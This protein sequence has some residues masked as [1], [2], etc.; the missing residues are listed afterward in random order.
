M[1]ALSVDGTPMP[2]LP[3]SA[4]QI[5]YDNTTSGLSA[6]TVKGAVDELA[7]EKQDKSDDSLQ[8]TDK[9]IPGAIN[10]LKSGLTNLVKSE[11]FTV[12]TD[13]TGN[14]KLTTEYRKIIGVYVNSNTSPYSLCHPRPWWLNNQNSPQLNGTYIEVTTTEDSYVHIKEQEVTG[15]YYYI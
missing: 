1:A 7:S 15:V 13:T 12:T 11:E 2:A 3:N 9:T 6:T 8:T 4:D 5:N 14:A 10:E